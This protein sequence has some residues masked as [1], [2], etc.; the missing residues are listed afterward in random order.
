MDYK[1][2]EFEEK[3]IQYWEHSKLYKTR[4]SQKQKYYVL[5]MFPYPSGK[6]HMGHV[7]NYTL[8][9]AF[10]RYMRLKGFDVLHPMGYD[11]L[12]LPA[13]NAAKKHHIHPEEWTL[14][15]IQEMKDQQI[16]LGLSYDW[17]KTV[18]TCLPEYY[19]FNQWFFLKLFEKG[20][21]YRK[22]APVNWCSACETVLANE[23]VEEGKCWRC[24]NA[25]I[26]KEL[27][28]WFF[29]I[30]DYAEDLL[31]DLESLPLWPDHVK[32][33]QKNWIGKS[34][35][36]TFSFEVEGS[37]EVLSI[38]TTRPDTVFGMSYVAVAPE[39]PLLEGWVKGTPYEKDV[40]SYKALAMD[41]STM[42][43]GNLNKEG[44]FTGRYIINPFTGQKHPIW[45]A[46]Y[47]LMTYASGAVM[48]VPAHDQRDF[49]FAKTYDLPILPIIQHD[50]QDQAYTGHG[51]LINSGQF[52]GLDNLVAKDL[53]ISFAEQQGFGKKQIQYRLRD[54]LIS[55]QRYWGTPIPIIHCDHCGLVP[56]K[57]LPVVLPKNVVFHATGNPLDTVHDF[58]NTHCPI[59]HAKAKRETDTM[60][61]FVDSS[62]Y[63]LRY[64]SPNHPLPFDTPLANHWMPVDQYIGGVEHAVLHLLYARFFTKVFYDLGLISTKEPFQQ[65]ITQGMVLKNG[66]KM[67]K[68]L[69]NVVD[70]GDIIQ[71]Y[72]A[73]TARL[74]I[75]FGAPIDRDLAWS[76]EGIEGC[77]RFLKRVFKLCTSL[78]EFPLKDE[79]QLQYYT[80]KTIKAVTEDIQRFSYNTAI[81]RMMELVNAMY[82]FGSNQHAC[83][84]LLILLSPF[85]PFITEEIWSLWGH[86]T[87]IHQ[88]SWP[89]YDDAK[90][91]QDHVT[92]VFMVNGKLRHK[93]LF[94]KGISKETLLDFAH[95]HE[96]LSQFI[97]TKNIQNV[98]FVP[99]KLINIVCS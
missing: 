7:R 51:I 25:V 76:D 4:E 52:S 50:S 31:N 91:T 39:H 59:C 62:W 92:I 16:R 95:Q 97:S 73:D 94:S 83:Q 5:E 64:V 41:R 49:E 96:K 30:T 9:D 19:Q 66:V 35:G 20:L 84:V 34:V 22:K 69:G 15:K 28:Q 90:L 23:Q 14:S 60:D 89:D 27:T 6:L 88:E 71:K 53:I 38:F 33:M 78:S 3:W 48:A 56:E 12:G 99:D 61:T 63:F 82:Q 47:V 10:A 70:P 55:R 75:L 80:H 93:D 57:N 77:F 65:L 81:S 42:E 36:A 17:D 86:K 21:A 46:D 29:K 32:S 72:G 2:L 8:G 24:K 26:L 68:S 45:V 79:K 40:L 1:P 87:S 58:I 74:F 44:V 85:V 11:S 18:V 43:R 37:K 54:W 67:S 13:E 98:I